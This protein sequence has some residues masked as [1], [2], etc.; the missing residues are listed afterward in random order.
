MRYSRECCGETKECSIEKLEKIR[1]WRGKRLF[2]H[3][4][5]EKLIW[6]ITT[7]EITGLYFGKRS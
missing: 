2:V 7:E 3:F 4:K 1:R 5:H 6:D